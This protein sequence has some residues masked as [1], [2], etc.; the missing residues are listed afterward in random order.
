MTTTSPASMGRSAP[1]PNRPGPRHSS[2]R[3]AARPRRPRPRAQ[4]GQLGGE[5]GG[6]LRGGRGEGDAD[7][8][9]GRDVG[10]ARQNVRHDSARARPR[11]V[12]QYAHTAQRHR[13]QRGGGLRGDLDPQPLRRGLDRF[14]GGR[15]VHDGFAGAR[16]P[17][18]PLTQVLLGQADPRQAVVELGVGHFRDLP[19]LAEGVAVVREDLEGHD[20]AVVEGG[21]HGGFG[22]ADPHRSHRPRQAPLL[23]GGVPLVRGAAQ[24]VSDDGPAAARVVG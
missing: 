6:G 3:P 4:T 9:V 8:A 18:Q 11:A 1:R 15:G 17:S 23:D 16:E 21:R 7:L 13:D 24:Q 5:P 19:A 10:G 22:G 14:G 2:S 20:L 12:R